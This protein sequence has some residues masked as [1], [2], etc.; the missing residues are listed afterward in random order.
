MGGI[1]LLRVTGRP[2]GVGMA[3]IILR[4]RRPSRSHDLTVLCRESALKLEEELLEVISELTPY[5][6]VARYPNAGLERPWENI[7]KETA[8]RLLKG[9]QRTVEAIG[10][11]AGLEKIG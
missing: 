5:Y 9:A 1:G 8:K 6:S 3:A 2:G 4:R 11:E 10:K 7:S